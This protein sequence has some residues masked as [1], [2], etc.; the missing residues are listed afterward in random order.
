[1][2]ANA[3]KP[4]SPRSPWPYAII[5][6]FVLFGTAMAAWVVVAVRN[7][8]DL[9]SADYYDREIRHQQ[10]I[11]RQARTLPVQSEVKVT[12]DAAQQRITVALP[13]AH[14]ALAWGKINF[15]RPSDAK[16]DHELKLALNPAGEQAVDAKPLQPGL[17]KVRVQWTFN[18]E[19]FYFDQTVV[20][21]SH[22]SAGCQPALRFPAAAAALSAGDDRVTSG[23]L[24]TGNGAPSLV[25]VAAK[26]AGSPRSGTS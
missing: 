26:R 10:Q 14:A 3:T 21:A 19:E 5:G 8:M 20:I 16:L 11:D 18:G 23:R 17:W 15:Y 6:W 4:T 2:N 9:V 22:R 13:A 25:A 7:D 12:Y 24:T 1:M